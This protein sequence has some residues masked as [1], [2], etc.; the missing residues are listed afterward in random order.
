MMESSTLVA[1]A[2]QTNDAVLVQ[3]PA[4]SRYVTQ[5]ACNIGSANNLT[6]PFYQVRP[7]YQFSPYQGPAPPTHRST[8]FNM[9]YHDFHPVGHENDHG[10]VLSYQRYPY[11][12]ADQ[13]PPPAQVDTQ[14]STV[15]YTVSNPPFASK[16]IIPNETLSVGQVANFGTEVDELMKAIQRKPEM[17]F[18]VG[19]QP[20]TLGMLPASSFNLESHGTASSSANKAATKRYR[21]DFPNCQQSFTG[22][23]TLIIHRRAH[24]GDK[25]YVSIELPTM[26][27]LF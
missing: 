19:Q 20:P 14:A 8:L 7:S 6:A 17:H 12:E 3:R 10:R 23:G 15:R 25:P 24:S 27:E 13:A 22:K 4:M 26:D 21:C 2:S 5:G 9:E 11:I 16:T 1:F 18:D